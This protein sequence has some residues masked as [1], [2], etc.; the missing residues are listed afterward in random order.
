MKIDLKNLPNN[1]DILQRIIIALNSENQ[2]LSEE[3]Q[4]LKNQ[5]ALLK[6]QR[7]GKSS[8]KLDKQIEEL[9]QRIEANGVNVKSGVWH[10]QATLLSDCSFTNSP[11]I[12]GTL[13]TT[14]VNNVNP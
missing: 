14:K 11:S 8:E 7:F 9:E 2:S 10:N 6:A 3:N 13:L 12:N 4:S 1:P 5:L